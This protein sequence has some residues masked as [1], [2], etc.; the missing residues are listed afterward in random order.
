[1]NVD[2]Y[3]RKIYT[4]A[5]RLTGDE[6]KADELASVAINNTLSKVRLNDK[7]TFS[8]FQKTTKDVIKLFISESYN[9]KIFINFEQNNIKV[10]SYQNAL[11][12]LNPISRAAVVWR[13]ILGFNIEDLE[14]ISNKHILYLELNNARRIMKEYLKEYETGA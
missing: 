7:V 10:E 4:V 3:F 9:D 14:E 2:N 12:S 5:F 13:D 6:M 1:L 11:M 8:L